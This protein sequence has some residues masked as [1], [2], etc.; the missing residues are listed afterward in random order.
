MK[1]D[2]EVTKSRD[3]LE[4]MKR[5]H[6]WPHGQMVLPV[7]NRARDRTLGIMTADHGTTVFE[8][9]SLFGPMGEVKAVAYNSYEDIV[10][11]GWEVD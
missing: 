4:M 5:P 7:I 8:N 1:T 11:D 6:L 2:E 9:M 3:H 10:A